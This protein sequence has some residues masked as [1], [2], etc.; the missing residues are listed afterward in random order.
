MSSGKAPPEVLH[1]LDQAAR[2]GAPCRVEIL[3]RRK[4][5]SEYWADTELQPIRDAQG[6]LLGFM[7]IGT[8]VTARMRDQQKIAELSDRMALA[9]EG[10]C[11]GFWDWMDVTQDAQWW[12]PN[13]HAMLGYLPQEL[14]PSVRSHLDIMHPDFLEQSRTLLLA[15]MAGG[16]AYDME[17]QLR[18]REAGY[19]WFRLR[20]KVFFDAQGKA[21]RMAGA[22]T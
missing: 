1:T 14:P 3:N 20:A 22:V 19:R 9:I 15:A 6:E 5:G 10:G 7:E 21:H 13:Y 4:D 11:D 17:L 16:P 18:T 8:D 12:S 2:N